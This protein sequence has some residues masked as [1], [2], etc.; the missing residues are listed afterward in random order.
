[1]EYQ[2]PQIPHSDHNQAGILTNVLQESERWGMRALEFARQVATFAPGRGSATWAEQKAAALIQDHLRRMGISEIST[3]AFRGQRSLWLFLGLTFGLAITGHA[4]YWL[5][6]QP[7]GPLASLVI[8]L[9]SFSLSAFLL[10]RKFTFRRHPLMATLPQ[11]E[12]QNVLAVIPPYQEARSQVVLIAHLDSQRAVWWYA[13]DF[14]TALITFLTPVGIYGVF[15][16]PLLYL[17]ADLSGWPGFAYCSL[18]LAV[19]H[20]TAWF[21][22]VTADLGVLSPGANDNASAVGT[23][24]ALAERLV[25]QPLYYTQ[26]WLAF[27]GCEE[28]G[29]DGMRTLLENL[30]NDLREALFL[31]FE[32]VGIGDRPAYLQSEGILR[33]KRISPKV[34][35]LVQ[36]TGAELGL[37]PLQ[38]AQFGAFTE[39]GTA[40]EHGFQAVCLLM[41]NKGT[42]LLPEWHRLTD[43]AD[44]L[45]ASAMEKIHTLA[46]KLLQ[47]IDKEGF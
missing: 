29:C 18:G 1:M 14:L 4:A 45:Q 17:L 33:P 21:T 27:T 12:S 37:R 23:V 8:M 47:T 42:D 36:S 19:L 46:W 38:A 28:S 35:R 13:S 32:L 26:V 24:L 43:R 6:K 9:A 2:E 22:G 40:W 31:D 34:E 20:F 30:G 11:G 5:L 3:Q 7:A 15:L 25:Q 39:A 44:Q 10:W 41:L 16:A